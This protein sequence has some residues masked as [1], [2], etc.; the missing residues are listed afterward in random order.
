[1]IRD[2]A[3][4]KYWPC[5]VCLLFG[6]NIELAQTKEPNATYN[7]KIRR[8]V[9]ISHIVHA[10]RSN[11]ICL[12]EVSYERCNDCFR[13]KNLPQGEQEETKG[14]NGEKEEEGKYNI[15]FLGQFITPM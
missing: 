10:N 14:T 15:Q 4:F 8:R 12:G 1:M 11:V 13:N 9:G 2:L 5:L 6:V 7:G 3:G